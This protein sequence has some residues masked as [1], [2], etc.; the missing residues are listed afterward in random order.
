M[1]ACKFKY[2]AVYVKGARSKLKKYILA[3]SWER[4]NKI[5]EGG[6]GA[7]FA[8]LYTYVCMAATTNSYCIVKS[9]SKRRTVKY[10]SSNDAGT[11]FASV[12][13]QRKLSAAPMRKKSC[14]LI[15]SFQVLLYWKIQ[16]FSCGGYRL[17]YLCGKNLKREEKRRKI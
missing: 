7:W 14:F 1:E 4:K 13:L 16:L 3:F 8:D 17:T 11:S 9:L 6:G 15:G 2:S 10:R 5:L 12:R